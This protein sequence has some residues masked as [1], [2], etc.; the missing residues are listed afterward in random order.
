M[1]LRQTRIALAAAAV[2]T[3]M[4]APAQ[5]QRI[6]DLAPGAASHAPPAR[7]EIAPA[8]ALSSTRDLPSALR[9]ARADAEADAR[10]LSVGGHAAVGAGAGAATGALAYLAFYALSDGCRTPEAMCGL[11]IPFLVGGGAVA[12]GAVGLVAGLIR[13]R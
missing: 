12:G 8:A 9:P 13:N 1:K 3:M 4:A 2:C 7:T 6:T 5:A 10:P 11:A